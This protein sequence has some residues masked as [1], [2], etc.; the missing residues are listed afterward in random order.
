MEP[1]HPLDGGDG[2]CFT[3]DR[4][5]LFFPGGTDTKAT[6][7][8]RRTTTS[9]CDYSIV[10]PCYRSGAWLPELVQ[11]VE[12]AVANVPGSFEVLLVNDAS[13]DDTWQVIESLAGQSGFVHGLD[14]MFNTGQFR[15]TLCGLEHA[16]GNQIVLMDDDLQHP[17]EAIPDLIA[18]L[19]AHPEWDC[20][21]ARFK[22]PRHGLLRRV[23][24]R[25]AAEL[26]CYLYGR[27]RKIAP[28]S[29]RILRRPLVE[30][31][32]RHGTVNP[33]IGPLIFRSTRRLGNVDVEHQPRPQGRSGYSI[34][35]LTRI[36]W[37]SIFSTSTVPLR[38]ASGIGF[39]S[40]VGSFVL[41]VIYFLRWWFG[42]ISE[43]GFITTVLLIIFFGG[44][45]LASVGLL[46]EY[47]V[48]IM[49]EVRRPVRY[50]IRERTPVG[51]R[52]GVDA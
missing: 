47:L 41:G 17:P 32:C 23:G 44:L 16:V 7:L 46:G 9:M 33:L 26:F 36:V 34:S 10:I 29:F 1:G 11:R 52:D 12:R 48:H 42:V 40:A 19:D 38:L 51:S 3:S 24:S 50:A 35:R 31:I 5:D 21:M 28:S 15:A 4:L 18:A 20:V 22:S 2:E 45:T 43:P 6:W 39:C 8:Q 30:T 49:E 27:P 14:M 25:V 13:P 37:Q